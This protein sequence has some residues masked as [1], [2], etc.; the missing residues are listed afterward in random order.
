[1]KTFLIFAACA[2]WPR[3][4]GIREGIGSKEYVDVMLVVVREKK[5]EYQAPRYYDSE[6]ARSSTITYIKS[7]SN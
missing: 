4:T 5:R 1:M 7:L 3:L 2:K 6:I